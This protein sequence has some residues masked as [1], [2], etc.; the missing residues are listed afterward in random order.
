MKSSHPSAVSAVYA[1]LLPAGARGATETALLLA[2]RLLFIRTPP[3][4]AAP[5]G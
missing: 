2:S 4:V 3:L 1:Q 5:A